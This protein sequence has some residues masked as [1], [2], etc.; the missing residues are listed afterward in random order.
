MTEDIWDLFPFERVE[1]DG[2]QCLR[3]KG[4][5]QAA[6]NPAFVGPLEE[7]LDNLR[8]KITQLNECLGEYE[9]HEWCSHCIIEAKCAQITMYVNEL[10]EKAEKLGDISAYPE[11]KFGHMTVLDFL[12]LVELQADTYTTR[13]LTAE[14]KLR[15]VKTYLEEM[16]DDEFGSDWQEIEIAKEL[17][18]ILE[19]ES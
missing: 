7:W 3:L 16:R 14:K 18:K 12:D 2:G 5:M 8:A 11:I 4:Y 13:A 17:L 9:S 10:K 19:G 15:A 6:M 1:G